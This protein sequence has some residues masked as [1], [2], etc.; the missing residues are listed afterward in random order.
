[1]TNKLTD[2]RWIWTELDDLAVLLRTYG[3][4]ELASLLDA[5]HESLRLFHDDR[6]PQKAMD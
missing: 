3:I 2:I 5:I 6:N 1:V 4:E